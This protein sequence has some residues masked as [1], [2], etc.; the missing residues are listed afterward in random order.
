MPKVNVHLRSLDTVECLC[1]SVE[2]P[3]LAGWKPGDHG[4]MLSNHWLGVVEATGQ[5]VRHDSGSYVM[6]IASAHGMDVRGPID[7]DGM[8]LTLSRRG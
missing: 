6:R 7:R 3:D 8:A 5:Q 1:S 2:K 4:H